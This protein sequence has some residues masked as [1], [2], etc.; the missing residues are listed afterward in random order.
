MPQATFRI[1]CQ[2]KEIAGRFPFFVLKVLF[3]GAFINLYV[4][5]EFQFSV[6]RVGGELVQFGAMLIKINEMQSSVL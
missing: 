6:A 3:T 4:F 2:T 5:S 1:Y